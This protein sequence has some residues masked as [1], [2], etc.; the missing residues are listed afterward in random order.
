MK[1]T[2]YI[3]VSI[4]IAL[5]LS[6][7]LS[8]TIQPRQVTI[9]HNLA[10]WPGGLV[11]DHTCIDI[12][13]IPEEWIEAA[14][15]SV[16]IHYA[17]TS[18]GSQIT[19]GLDRIESQNSTFDVSRGICSLPETT[20]SLCIFDGQDNN[21][22]DNYITPD[23]Y[24]ETQSG[25]D[26]TQGTLDDNPT[27]N[28]SLWSWCT[29]LNYY[30]T[31]EVEDYLSIIND[32]ETA[33]PNVTFV[34]MTCNAQ[35]TGSDGYNRW[36]NN[37]LIR[38]YCT[39][40]NKILFDFADLDCWSNGSQNTYEYDDGET[41]HTIPV[42]HEDFNGGEAGHTTYTSCE[43]KG[44]AFWWLV[45]S[46]AGWNAPETT[47]TTTTETTTTTTET[48]T[49]TTEE[50]TATTTE[51]SSTTT[52]TTTTTN[53]ATTTGNWEDIPLRTELFLGAGIFLASIV[54]L[55]LIYS[56]RSG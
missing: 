20:D 9:D 25:I 30:S 10:D 13:S 2:P 44:K 4:L 36:M 42:E 24:W 35:G 32:L 37:N 19:T 1:R 16:I 7:G 48:T 8:N 39:S 40:N 51:S 15:D 29:Q 38:D 53:V 47:T 33:N 49:T 54:V 14:Q 34:Y 22:G 27:L 50:T 23:E 3:I 55:S 17:H 26:L 31:E 46:L 5:L 21:G 43:Q 41:V 28:V 45:A 56:R 18:H 6:L 12:D 52:T 11:I